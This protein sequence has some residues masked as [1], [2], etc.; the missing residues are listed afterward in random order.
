MHN[1]EVVAYLADALDMKANKTNATTN[2]KD[3]KT[4]LR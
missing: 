1:D 4:I 3:D 2:R